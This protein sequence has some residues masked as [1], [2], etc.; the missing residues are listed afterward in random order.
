MAALQCQQ[1]SCTSF[2]L[3][4][5]TIHPQGFGRSAGKML[6]FHSNQSSLNA[7]TFPYCRGPVF[8]N[9]FLERNQ[10]LLVAIV[11]TFTLSSWNGNIYIWSYSLLTV[12]YRRRRR[13]GRKNSYKHSKPHH[14]KVSK[15][16]N[17]PPCTLQSAVVHYLHSKTT[18]DNV[19]DWWWR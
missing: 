6:G 19:S 5:H 12:F 13:W 7:F 11:K 16:K 4:N 8:M 2:L 15:D 17:S 1:E 10:R 14:I 3:F 9:V 18:A